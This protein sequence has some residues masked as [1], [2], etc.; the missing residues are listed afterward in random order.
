MDPIAEFLAPYGTVQCSVSLADLT[1]FKVGGLADYLLHPHDL[2]A[3]L[4]VSERLRQEGIPYKIL[5]NGSNILANDAPYHGVIVKL[6][7]CLRFLYI[8]HAQILV[9]AGHSLIACAYAASKAGLSGLE[10]AGGIPG[11]IGGAL[12]M[13]AGAYKAQM[14]QFVVEVLVLRGE[15][16]VWLSREQC[17]FAYRESVFKHCGDIIIAA[18]LQL[19]VGECE[20]SLAMM[21]ERQSRRQAS[22]PLAYP[23]AGSCFHNPEQQPAWRYIEA[24]GLRG[25]QIGGAQ[26]AMQHANFIINVNQ[27]K[28]VDIHALMTLVQQRVKAESGVD[29]C[30]EIELFN[31]TK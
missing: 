21:Q 5:G 24:S 8:D 13:N 23:S 20:K 14:S 9:G 30:L 12:Y 26:V 15:Q 16:L 7:R 29:L 22:Q 25:Y 27:A 18:R 28:A 2:F 6:T 4:Q 3:L 11:T 1:T 19:S 17:A 10:W 31:W